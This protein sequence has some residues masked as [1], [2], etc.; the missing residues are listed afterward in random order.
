MYTS[1]TIAQFITD[2]GYKPFFCKKE[3]KE[4]PALIN[5][6]EILYAIVEVQ[7]KDV[8]KQASSGYGL[9]IATNQRILCYRKSIINTVTS[10]ELPLLKI[11]GISYRKGLMNGSIIVTSAG[12]ES[13]FEGCGKSKAEKFAKIVNDLLSK[14]NTP[15]APIAHSQPNHLDQLEKLFELKQKGIITENEFA[16][17]KAKLLS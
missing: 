9:A 10:E 1:E 11:T 5:D 8:H 15:I 17:Q 16:E 6:G 3:I 2:Y 7:F 4:L 14:S 13:I 12:N